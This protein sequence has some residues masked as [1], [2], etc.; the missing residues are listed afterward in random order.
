MPLPK[1]TF[2]DRGKKN[3]IDL[4]ALTNHFPKYWES[5]KILGKVFGKT[6]IKA[7]LLISPNPLQDCVSAVFKI[8][9]HF[10]HPILL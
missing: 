7:S 6:I 5:P 2:R 9:K 1:A 3:F 4:S 10:W 8:R